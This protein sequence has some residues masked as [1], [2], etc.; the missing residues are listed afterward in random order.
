M[1]NILL[2]ALFALSS[3]TYTI[4]MVHTQGEASDVIEET[5]SASA[6]VDPQLNIPASILPAPK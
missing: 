1:K 3:C 5:S 6:K 2:F 4:S